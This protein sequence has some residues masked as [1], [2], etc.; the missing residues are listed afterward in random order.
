MFLCHGAAGTLLVKRLNEFEKAAGQ[1]FNPL[2]W[3]ACR[4]LRR[5][6][7]PLDVLNQDWIHGMLSDGCLFKE[8]DLLVN[9]DPATS[10][11]DYEAFL[12]SDFKFPG[13]LEAK[14]SRL[15]RIFDGYRNDDDADQGEFKLKGD[16]SEM[17]SVYA[18]LRH[19]VELTFADRQDELLDARIS[20][21]SCCRFLIRS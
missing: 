2:A 21:Y 13:W 11:E 20:F 16:A 19:H 9:A 3:H 14:G 5:Y 4:E 15:W 8:I 17:L 7:R 6:V 1:K 18:L 12:K 10:R